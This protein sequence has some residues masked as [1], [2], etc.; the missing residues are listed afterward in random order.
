MSVFI[1]I[2][3]FL[4]YFLFPRQSITLIFYHSIF[5]VTIIMFH[6][7]LIMLLTGKPELGEQF[8]GIRGVVCFLVVSVVCVRLCKLDS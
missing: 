3:F 4:V 1:T 2:I 5:N 7:L 6:F 8:L